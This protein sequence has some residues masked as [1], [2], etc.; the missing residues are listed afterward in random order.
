MVQS[1]GRTSDAGRQGH[2]VE[3]RGGERF[4]FGENWKSFL[5]TLDDARVVRAEAS[6][7]QM[8]G[9]D[10]LAGRS[11]LDVGA[12]SGLFSLAAR[13]LGAHVHSFDYDPTSV[14]C[15]REL[16]NRFGRGEVDW[17]IEEGSVLDPGFLSQ[18]GTFDVVYSWGVLHHTGDMWAALE[19]IA[20][21]VASGGRLF[22][23]LYNDQGLRSR[24]W[25]RVKR[26]YCRGALGR[27]AVVGTF[28][29][30]FILRDLT[31][32]LL[33]GRHPLSRYREYKKKRGMS[34]THDWLDW[35]GGL[36]FEVARPD[37]V[38]AF[39]CQRGL[40]LEKLVTVGG[41]SGNNQFVLRSLM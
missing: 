29:P 2:E 10:D 7:R 24:A 19:N 17:Q 40:S 9:V 8:L 15:T 22:I 13:R 5:R 12:G 27:A 31:R 25:L 21:K 3:V 16:R 38:V 23:A 37:D 41:G 39:C 34:R 33:A 11:F 36:P 35:L 6:L 30:T 1:T 28:V 32:D 26:A 4:R 14:A 18:L 20:A